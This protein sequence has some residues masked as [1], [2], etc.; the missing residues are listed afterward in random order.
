MEISTVDAFQGREK[1]VIIVSTVRAAGSRG[2]GFL[3]DVR[4]MNVALTRAKH[5][6]FVVGSA[7][8]LA[9]NP[10]WSE[11]TSLAVRS[12]SLLRVQDPCCDLLALGGPSRPAWSGSSAGAG[13]PPG[14][15]GSVSLP[16]VPKRETHVG[17]I[18]GKAPLNGSGRRSPAK[19]WTVDGFAGRSIEPV[20]ERFKKPKPPSRP[21]GVK[22]EGGPKVNGEDDGSVVVP[23]PP[24][25]PPRPPALH[26]TKDVIRSEAPIDPRVRKRHRSVGEGQLA[27][28]RNESDGRAASPNRPSRKRPRENNVPHEEEGVPSE[29]QLSGANVD[30]AAALHV[31][32]PGAV[33]HR[34]SPRRN[35]GAT[36]TSS[37]GSC[38]ATHNGLAGV[39]GKGTGL[40][41]ATDEKS[42]SGSPKNNLD[43]Q[44][45]DLEEGELVP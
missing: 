40:S 28:S 20:A 18:G 23:R 34:T 10:K 31:D 27:A 45:D 16:L 9:V 22:T 33:L 1:D 44:E 12:G 4:R 41:L 29:E 21:R 15:S 7:E 43:V 8:A 36:G 38:I 24:P 35:D 19:E 26:A 25:H 13:P 42:D 14:T 6:L 30:N 11:L 3:A 17:G 2:I 37:A 39:G 32:E 5:G